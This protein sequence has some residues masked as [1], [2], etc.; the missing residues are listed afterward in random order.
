[1]RVSWKAKARAAAFL[2]VSFLILGAR[3]ARAETLFAGSPLEGR[4]VFVEKGCVRCHSIW[5]AGGVVGPDLTRLSA[6]ATIS[7]FAGL[8]W[9]HSPRMFEAMKRA[10]IPTPTIQPDE[11]ENLI[12]YLFTLS[13]FDEPG[14]FERGSKDFHEKR[15]TTCHSVGGVGG[16][17]GP[18]LDKYAGTMSSVKL[19]QAIWNHG[20][21]MTAKMGEKN[22]PRPVFEKEDLADILAFIRGSSLE[23]P[24]N[25]RFEEPGNPEHGWALF[26]DKGCI[27]CHSI[28]GAGGKVGPDLGEKRF[29][30]RVSEVAAD[31]WNH[32]PK[33]WQKMQEKGIER[34]TFEG[35]ELA[36]ILAFLYRAGLFEPPG[37]ASRGKVLFKEKAC[38]RCHSVAGVGG[39]IAP[40]LA[41]SGALT[42]VAHFASAL[43][44][45]AAGMQEMLRKQGI[46][47]P[48]FEKSQ[49]NDLL[50]YFQNEARKARATVPAK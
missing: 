43:W 22:V 27:K 15:C 44:N 4:K 1:M 47:W 18:H 16:E 46:P 40:D 8:L 30:G 14:N 38:V 19:A 29:T 45:H 12:A 39:R 24:A 7:Q 50:A 48:A 23:I 17:V 31:L 36:D 13:Y 25:A 3:V 21:K 2:A 35:N 6:R 9:D 34:P 20:V 33:M 11:M 41:R 10:G 37:S 49:I 42:S 32:G 28:F 5:G 26:N